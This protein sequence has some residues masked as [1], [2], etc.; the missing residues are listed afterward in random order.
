MHTYALLWYRY[1]LMV[2]GKL[3]GSE[4]LQNL[5][6]RFDASHVDDLICDAH[7]NFFATTEIQAP[8]GISFTR[9]DSRHVEDNIAAP[10]QH[11]CTRRVCLL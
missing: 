7:E 10:T 4:E 6:L 1:R 3:G 8:H 5:T 9:W 11:D 2:V